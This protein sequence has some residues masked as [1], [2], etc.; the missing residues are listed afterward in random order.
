MISEEYKE[1]DIEKLLKFGYD[2]TRENFKF[3]LGI[4]AAVII[5]EITRI[6]IYFQY[7]DNIIIL[8]IITAFSFI[9]QNLYMMGLIKISL[10]IVNGEKP[11]F[12]DLFSHLHLFLGY[13]FAS[14]VYGLM[15]IIGTALFIAPGI[16]IGTKFSLYHFFIIDREMETIEALKASSEATKDM[17][18][19]LFS[20]YL[21]IIMLIFAGVVFLFVGL[22]AA[23]PISLL[24]TSKIYKL[25][26][27]RVKPS[28]LSS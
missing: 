24:A 7:S 18:L 22:L 16:I 25:L 21:I 19:W 27:Q 20:Y 1:F 3:L 10:K 9:L 13:L 26:S 14:F 12:E 8:I 17:K 11:Q 28:L 4:L 15:V 6:L 23:I 5:I 2:K